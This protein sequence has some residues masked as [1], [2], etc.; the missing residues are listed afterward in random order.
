MIWAAAFG[1]GVLAVLRLTGRGTSVSNRRLAA[2]LAAN[3]VMYIAGQLLTGQ[4]APW[5]W[6]L[7]V[8]CICSF[9][10]LHPPA[11]RTAAV[12][13]SIYVL[14]IIIH[15]AFAAAGS[16]STALLYLD[17]LAIGGWCQLLVLA[18]GAIQHGRKRKVGVA[19]RGS[20]DHQVAAGAHP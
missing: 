7:A 19:G 2:V 1:A 20:G 6:F 8:D 15:I 17:L 5:L 16:A 11:S 12:I 10:V 9:V 4:G 3:F 13:G 18:T 14:Q